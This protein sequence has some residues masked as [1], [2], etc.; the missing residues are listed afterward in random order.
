MHVLCVSTS[1]DPWPLEGAPWRTESKQTFGIGQGGEENAQEKT[2][3]GPT[4]ETE[5][6]LLSLP[7]IQRG[8]TEFWPS[9]QATV[10]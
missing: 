5:N 7:G 4:V 6:G 1:R 2:Q 9:L 3:H 8:G 10:V